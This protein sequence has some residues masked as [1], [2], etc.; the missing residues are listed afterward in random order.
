MTLLLLQ[1]E[2]TPG[3]ASFERHATRT[4]CPEIVGYLISVD[5]PPSNSRRSIRC[6]SR[7][8]IESVSPAVLVPAADPPIDEARRHNSWRADHAYVNAL[9]DLRALSGLY[10]GGRAHESY[11]NWCQH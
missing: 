1:K 10:T 2:P 9:P 3:V 5:V 8:L 11:T 4:A 6:Q 7:N